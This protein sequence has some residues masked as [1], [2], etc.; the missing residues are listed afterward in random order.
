MDQYLGHH[1]LINLTEDL[2]DKIKAHPE[3]RW[4]VVGRE[5]ITKYLDEIES[6]K[7]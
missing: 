7:A 5:L 1:V 4:S 3:I 6:K 2:W